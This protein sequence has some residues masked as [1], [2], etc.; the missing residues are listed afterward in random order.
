MLVTEIIESSLP[1]M[2]FERKSRREWAGPCV[3]CG[4]EDRMR[5]WPEG[6]DKGRVFWC[7]QCGKSGDDVQFLRDF[8][9]YSY[10]DALAECGRCDGNHW[11]TKRHVIA[12][13]QSKKAAIEPVKASYPS[14]EWQATAQAFLSSCRVEPVRGLT[15]ETCKACGIV[16]NDRD[17]F[18]DRK[19]WGLEDYTGKD[20]KLHTKTLIPRG[21]VIVTRR[22]CG[23]V[24]VT[25]RCKDADM[26][27]KGRDKYHDMPNGAGVPYFIGREGKPVV[28]VE[29]ALDA[30][31]VWQ[32]SKGELAAVALMGNRKN[33]DAETDSFLRG[34][35]ALIC[36]P[37]NDDG[38]VIGGK[39]WL[40]AYPK[41]LLIAPLEG[42]DLGERPELCPMWCA[43]A[44]EKVAEC[45]KKVEEKAHIEK[46]QTVEA[47]RDKNFLEVEKKLE[48]PVYEPLPMRCA[49]D[50]IE[51]R[52]CCL[53][54]PPLPERLRGVV[55]PDLRGL[56]V[57]MEGLPVSLRGISSCGWTLELL[58]GKLELKQASQETRNRAG[59]EGYL[60][61]CYE[62]VS[63]AWRAYH[64]G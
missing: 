54:S 9:D 23:V 24:G 57:P 45:R 36:A 19:A 38:G 43:V 51:C 49:P 55:P 11:H 56:G 8:L 46:P 63:S 12:K 41:A 39:E 61:V 15:A 37:D 17:R 60:R 64:E 30:C 62:A 53:L 47:V 3:F 59:C 7:R 58:D 52:P 48:A 44:L 28:I 21:I 42:K 20:G 4:G 35:P 10:A 22:K 40:S 25:V 31:L 1:A 14:A 33:V 16:V 29:S 26:E 5:V 2:N 50:T 13:A 6:S 34:A 18:P 27:A 32:S